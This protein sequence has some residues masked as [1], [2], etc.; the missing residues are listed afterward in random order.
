MKDLYWS[1]SG[2]VRP[3]SYLAG[4]PRQ[5]RLPLRGIAGPPGAEVDSHRAKLRRARRLRRP[6]EHL[7]PPGDFEVDEPGCHD[8]GVK[9]RL[10][11]S[12]GDSALPEVDVALGPFTHRLLHQD[13][14][15]LEPAARL[16]HPR[17][18]TEPGHLVREEIHHPV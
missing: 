12:A 1:R 18:F 5:R 2:P 11:Q 13:V 9:L 6:A 8:R 7:G 14:A 4:K 17:H 3:R 15:D 16:E 10:E